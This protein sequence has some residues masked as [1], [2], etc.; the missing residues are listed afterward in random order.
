[1]HSMKFDGLVLVGLICLGSIQAQEGTKGTAAAPATQEDR[2]ADRE[3][4]RATVKKFVEACEQGDAAAAAGLLTDGAEL[5]PDDAPPIRGKQAVMEAFKQRFDGKQKQ[6]IAIEVESVRFTSRDT[7]LE[8][9][10]LKTSVNKQA[11]GSHRYS[12]MHVREDGKWLI[13]AIR[14]WPSEEAPLRDLEWL[15]GSWQ[16]QR[17]DLAI[18]TTYE[19]VGQKAFIRGNIQTR[20]KDKTISA[21][22]MIGIDPRT[23]GLRI[24]IFEAN[25]IYATGSCQRDGNAWVFETSGET[26][27]GVPVA[28]KN[29]LYYVNAD[30]F[31]WQPVQ[32]RMGQEQI[33]DL[34]PIKVNRVKK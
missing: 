23:G 27:E 8:E 34:P 16:A 10:H 32:L 3:G 31:T 9:G 20:Q 33:A 2:P 12:L 5:M 14:E 13:A 15:I 30:A 7:A 29:I 19:W 18:S 17:D 4:I 22:Q 6:K 24:W 25:G 11:G 28:A 1:M 26:P 21:M